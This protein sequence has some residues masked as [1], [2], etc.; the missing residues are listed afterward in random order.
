MEYVQFS[1]S[2][3][4]LYLLLDTYNQQCID[5][6][7]YRTVGYVIKRGKNTF[8]PSTTRLTPSNWFLCISVELMKIIEEEKNDTRVG[9]PIPVI[10]EAISVNLSVHAPKRFFVK[11][12]K[13]TRNLLLCVILAPL[14]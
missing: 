10:K 13:G 2:S 1:Y 6:W 11:H 3:I 9:T 7:A 4:N 12:L 14:L 8:L 5:K